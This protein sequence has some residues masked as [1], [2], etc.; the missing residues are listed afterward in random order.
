MDSFT[1]DNSQCNIELDIVDVDVA[2]NVVAAELSTLS[3]QQNAD[4]GGGST[5]SA[6]FRSDA[7]KKSD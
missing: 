1:L 4:C 2:E 5:P 3:L 6:S 7:R